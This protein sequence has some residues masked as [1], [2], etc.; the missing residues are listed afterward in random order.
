MTAKTKTARKPVYLVWGSDEYEATKRTHELVDAL[1]PAAEQAFGLETIDGRV[2]TIELVV[3][4]INKCLAALRT[5]GFFGSEKTIWLRDV[6]FLVP[7]RP[8]GGGESDDGG[9]EGGGLAEEVKDR[10]AALTEEIR[11]G[12][13]DGQT[14]VINTDK[15]NR[16]SALYKAIQA[17]GEVAEFNPPEKAK[18]AA[19]ATADY[20]GGAFREAGLQIRGD[21]IEEFLDRTGS[22]TRQIRNEIEKLALYLGGRKDVRL[23]DIRAI[24]SA[25]REAVAWD[26][27]E[28][29]G[30]RNLA[31]ALATLRHL[32]SQKESPQMIIAML[33]GRL[34]DLIVLRQCLDRRWISFRRN[35]EWVNVSWAPGAE[36][37][38][39]LA[40]L[41]KDPRAMNKFRIGFMVED[42]S[43]Y[44]FEELLRAHRLMTEAHEKMQ[45][46]PVPP[47]ILLEHLLVAVMG[48]EG[49]ART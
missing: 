42:A 33:E 14:L 4:A 34:R 47:D 8:A 1:C 15:I 24:V 39:L 3:A 40:S 35:G 13:P 49:R 46:A 44:S 6:K 2:D 5:V 31:A 28:A 20:V 18:E 30:K 17:A 19:R 48:G 43:R 29:L 11:K 27:T 22:D 37:D 26:L 41:P 7:R 45:S 9:G 21:L 38:A 10:L 12:I 32:L 25:T 23:E 16:A 36:A